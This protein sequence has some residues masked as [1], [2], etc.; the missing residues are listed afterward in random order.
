MLGLTSFRADYMIFAGVEAHAYDKKEQ[1][2]LRERSVQN[3]KTIHL[4]I[5]WFNSVKNDS[6]WNLHFFWNVSFICTRTENN[7]TIR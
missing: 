3:Q 6:N 1:I 7:C 2:D 5:I 4:S